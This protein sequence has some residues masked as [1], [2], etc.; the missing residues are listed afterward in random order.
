M[1]RLM[2]E[3]R[4]T[5][6]EMDSPARM[7][8]RLRSHSNLAVVLISSKTQQRCNFPALFEFCIISYIK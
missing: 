6:P 1:S 7:I 2:G 5:G 8:F 3:G 4:K